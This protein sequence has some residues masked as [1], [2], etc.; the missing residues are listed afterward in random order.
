M[1]LYSPFIP[2]RFE[3]TRSLALRRLLELSWISS[4]P[5]KQK[6]I[7]NLA[8]FVFVYMQRK[9]INEKVKENFLES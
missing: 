2:P 5:K 4:I 8:F 9:Q 1:A 6:P 7:F 3:F